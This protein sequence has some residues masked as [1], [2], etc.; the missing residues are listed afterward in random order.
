ML[1][2]YNS[3]GKKLMRFYPQED[4]KVKMYTCGPTVWNYAH[5]GNLRTFVFYDILRRYLK[6]KGY[7]VVHV[8][9]ITDVEDRIID[10]V[11]NTGKKLK[12]LTSF[13]EKELMADLDSLNVERFE[14]YPR[15]TE[16]IDDIV[17]LIK[18]LMK[19]G[20]AYK[21][22]DGSIYFNVSKFKRYGMLSG[23]RPAELKTGAR[24]SLDHYEKEDVKDFALWKAW[25]ERDGE[26]YWDTELGRGR[27]GWHIEC[28]AMSMK[29]LGPTLDI[30]AGGKD[31]R[32]P[33]H[34]NEIAQSEAATGKKF[35]RFWLHTEFL[36]IAGEEMH[37][38]KGNYITLRDKLKEGWDPLTI[39]YFLISSH[40]RD[41]LNL[42]DKA[43]KQAENSRKRLL[44]FVF[45]LSSIST[46]KGNPN[47][48]KSVSRLLKEFEKAMDSDL[49]VPKALSSLF[50]FVREV[51]AMIDRGEVG[52]KESGIIL[53]AVRK[54]DSVLGIIGSW[55]EKLPESII[56]KIRERERA[57][58]EGKYDLADRIRE[59]LLELGVVLEDTQAGTVWKLR[60]KKE[61]IPAQTK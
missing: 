39:R 20:Y 14:Y 11:R 35:V 9:N 48:N 33:H 29:Y 50:S 22:P 51:N 2:L 13:Y 10:A 17:E 4:K 21:A 40:Y 60:S 57:R 5:L 12:D 23:V 52:K 55:P 8:M 19:K 45:R 28:S 30:H 58:K 31:L 61:N 32:F 47:I 59:E 34:E 1:F 56:A 38:S 43:L 42:T 54:I 16:H 3:L 15:A 37:K 7:T 41:P 53:D 36:H 46:E 27:P 44:D 25:D 18:K 24:V 6:Y 26:I 49:N